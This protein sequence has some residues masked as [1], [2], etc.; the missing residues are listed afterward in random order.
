MVSSEVAVSACYQDAIFSEMRLEEPNLGY[1]L[2]SMLMAV[3]QGYE[4]YL[5][6][7]IVNIHQTEF[8]SDETITYNE[9]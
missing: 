6:C 4:E 8:N 1:S 2:Q 9:T 3:T 7:Y 5:N